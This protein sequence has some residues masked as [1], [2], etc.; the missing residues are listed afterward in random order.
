MQ[1]AR[2][3]HQHPQNQHHV[4]HFLLS[5]LLF[6]SFLFYPPR[7]SSVLSFLFCLLCSLFL[8]VREVVEEGN[9][10]LSTFRAQAGRK[11]E[12][13]RKTEKIFMGRGILRI[14]INELR[15]LASPQHSILHRVHSGASPPP[16]NSSFGCTASPPFL[17]PVSP[18]IVTASPPLNFNAQPA[19]VFF[20]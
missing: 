11:T 1:Q 18:T 3:N 6:S 9:R 16:P 13:Q 2:N 12:K 17:F 4:L 15:L 5:S 20:S 14:S 10:F 19:S 8:F 7:F